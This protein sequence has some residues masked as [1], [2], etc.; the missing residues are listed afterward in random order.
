MLI[1]FDLI[2]GGSY[3]EGCGFTSDFEFLLHAIRLRSRRVE[4]A[5]LPRMYGRID[6]YGGTL[7]ANIKHSQVGPARHYSKDNDIRIQ[8]DVS[9]DLM[10]EPDMVRRLR[11]SSLLV[12]AAEK[13]TI[14][15]RQVLP[16]HVKYPVLEIVTDACLEY[17]ALPSP[18]PNMFKMRELLGKP[19]NR[20]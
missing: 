5:G 16:E 11:F 10:L 14:R 3:H 2:L 17:M 13:T 12:T 4:P 20:G 19:V 7:C 8:I 18:L 15:A 9:E 1:G 6:I